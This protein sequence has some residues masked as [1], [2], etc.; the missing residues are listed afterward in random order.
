MTDQRTD[1]RRSGV[2]RREAGDQKKRERK[3]RKE[4]ETSTS[5]KEKKTEENKTIKIVTKKTAMT[6]TK[7]A[8]RKGKP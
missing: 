2:K 1:E 7:T 3:K 8:R 5:M 4:R 6:G